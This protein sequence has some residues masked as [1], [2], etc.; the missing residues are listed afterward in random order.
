MQ[1]SSLAWMLRMPLIKRWSLIFCVK[2]EN[3]A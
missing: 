2:Q 3:I 1:S